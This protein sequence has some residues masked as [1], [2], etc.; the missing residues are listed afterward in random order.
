MPDIRELTDDLRCNLQH[1]SLVVVVRAVEIGPTVTWAAKPGRWDVTVAVT[2][3]SFKI[4]IGSATW[5]CC[6]IVIM[7]P[8]AAAAWRV[9]GRGISAIWGCVFRQMLAM[10]MAHHPAW[11][12]GEIECLPPQQRPLS[13]NAHVRNE[14]KILGYNDLSGMPV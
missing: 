12:R 11:E 1:R 2:S 13:V 7:I 6:V 14:T 8:S 3:S 10:S 9:P 5:H 4:G